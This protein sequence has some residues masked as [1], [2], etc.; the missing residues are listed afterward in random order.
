MTILKRPEFLWPAIIIAFLVGGTT[1]TLSVLVASKSDGGVQVVENYYAKAASWDS[2][3][4]LQR[5]SDSLRW[6]S[7]IRTESDREQRFGILEVTDR[8]GSPVTDLSGALVITRP[9]TTAVLSE[10]TISPSRDKPGLYR[11]PLPSLEQG[12]WDISIDAYSGDDRYVK[13]IRLDL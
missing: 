8:E 11:F 9:Q 13:T 7:T 4:T 3:A 12:L 5:S 6:K 2:L 1:M 10:L